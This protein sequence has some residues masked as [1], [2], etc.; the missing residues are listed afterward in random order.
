M[1][2]SKLW[3]HRHEI[4]PEIES[5][6]SDR[7]NNCSNQSESNIKIRVKSKYLVK[8]SSRAAAERAAADKAAAE[9]EAAEKAAEEKAA[10]ERAAAEKAVAEKAAA[11]KAASEKAA[12]EKVA[13]EKMAAER[14]AA[15][16]AAAAEKEAA[17][18]VAAAAAT[19][20]SDL[21]DTAATVFECLLTGSEIA[22]AP[23]SV[24]APSINVLHQHS[25]TYDALPRSC[26]KLCLFLIFCTFSIDNMNVYEISTTRQQT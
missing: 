11:E 3:K 4:S 7:P 24:T 2:N 12:A 23:P 17:E 18:K 14:E 15:A 26:L 8:E 16:K 21:R 25:E 5:I 20:P 1:K 19:T 13:A 22:D 9:K 10:A 6:H